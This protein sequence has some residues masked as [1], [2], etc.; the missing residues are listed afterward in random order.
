MSS[1]ASLVRSRPGSAGPLTPRRELSPSIHSGDFR[2][3][4]VESGYAGTYAGGATSWLRI[5]A[6]LKNLEELVDLPDIEGAAAGATTLVV[7]PRYVAHD[8]SL[9]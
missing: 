9:S 1:A 6:Q 2:D 3:G 8:H 5:E 4:V 7:Q